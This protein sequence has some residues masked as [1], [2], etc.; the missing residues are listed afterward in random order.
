M[1]VAWVPGQAC[2]IKMH[3]TQGAVSK[4]YLIYKG[5]SASRRS[6]EYTFFF[7]FFIESHCWR[8]ASSLFSTSTT[9]GL[10]KSQQTVPYIRAQVISP[11]LSWFAS[12]SLAVVWYLVAT[13]AYICECRRLTCPAQSY[14]GLVVLSPTSTVCVFE[15]QGSNYP[16]YT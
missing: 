3:P 15:V 5:N 9:R 6:L 13:C 7:S 16:L 2:A 12:S 4:T 1:R 8:R 14:F 11:T 10:A